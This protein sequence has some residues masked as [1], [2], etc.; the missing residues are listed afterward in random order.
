MTKSHV[1]ESRFAYECGN[2]RYECVM[3]H[4]YVINVSIGIIAR[5]SMTMSHMNELRRTYQYVMSHSYVGRVFISVIACQ[6]ITLSH[7]NESRLNASIS[8][9]NA[10]RH[11][12]M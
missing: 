4:S 3:P 9:M 11:I 10:S 7:V 1:N 12:H 5:Q 8:R 6:S 2:L